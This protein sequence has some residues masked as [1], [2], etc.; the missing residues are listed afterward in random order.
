M[1]KNFLLTAIRNIVRNRMF[2]IIN[3]AGLSI[4]IACVILILLWVKDE[5]SYDRFHE[6]SDRIFRI[7]TKFGNETENIWTTSP[8]PLGS[9]MADKYPDV[10]TYTRYLDAGSL[11]KYEDKVFYEDY[12]KL[13]DQSFLEM[14]SFK[15]IKGN[16]GEAL[17]SRSAVVITESVARKYFGDTDPVGKVLTINKTEFLT[18][19]G[20]IQDPPGNTIF[21]FSLLANMEHVPEERLKSWAFDAKTFIQLKEGVPETEFQSKID[22]LYRAILP[23]SSAVP[24][25]QNIKE[26]YLNETGKPVRLVFVKVF[27][28]TAIIILLLACINYMNLNTARSI[29]RSKEI[30]IRKVTGASK[31]S[32]ILQF[33]GESLLLTLISVIIALVLTELARP[34]FNDLAVKELKI[35]YS[36][37]VFIL[38]IF[39]ILIFTG[40][41]SGL[42]PAF[43]LSSFTPIKAL[44]G[45]IASG[46]FGKSFNNFLVVFQFTITVILI[47]VSMAIG[48]QIR[49]ITNK[50][51]GLNKDKILVIPFIPELESKFDAIKNEI[52]L[53]PSIVSVTGA[54]N[55]PTNHNSYVIFNWEGNEGDQ[56]IGVFYNM[57]DYDFVETMGME[58]VSGR[59]FSRDFADDDSI[60]Y[61][62]NESAQ[63]A[64]NIKD[65]IGLE[66]EFAHPYFPEHL[67]KGRIIGVVKDFHLRPLREKVVPFAMRMYR[68]WYNYVLIKYNTD[69]TQELINFLEGIAK[70]I[71][72]DYQFRY[73]F[74]DQE[75]KDLYIVE[76]KAARIIS[77][78]TILSIIISC[79]GLLGLT[80]NEL[81][82]KTKQIGIR[83]AIG[84]STQNLILFFCLSFT[85]SVLISLIFASILA[86]IAINKILQ[87][88]AYKTE[89]TIWLFLGAFAIAL[90]L[91]LSTIIYQTYKSSVKNP[92]ESLRYE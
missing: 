91:A 47:I 24:Y 54:Y 13:V 14:F 45:V 85:K 53:N 4:G 66:V 78:F 62:I 42:Y 21:R 72:P 29:R 40:I 70:K 74:F 23:N 87:Q 81:E 60:S 90:F 57:A 48:K 1:V 28:M 2:S 73:S 34:A 39:S 44:K 37:P 38:G 92:V 5:L 15:F 61:I 76:Y 84:G 26:V 18:V 71:A 41:V 17:K 9:Y 8:F 55:L 80:I 52:L 65:P 19:T 79:L 6:N 77:Y 58:L 30:G 64:M 35:G 82:Q 12:F 69:N 22:S 10:E 46:K 20:V 59:S 43:I 63:K 7:I 86:E 89:I 51:L 25:L 3:I 50:D 56:G 16:K 11:V 32:I 88:Y 83:K 67:R 33:L 68:P 36:D 49:Y 75:V 31:G 27:S